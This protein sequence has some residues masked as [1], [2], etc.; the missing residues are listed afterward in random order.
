MNEQ[1][2]PKPEEP[3]VTEP[4]V[5]TTEGEIT[6]TATSDAF[7]LEKGK[8]RAAEAVD[9]VKQAGKEITTRPLL[10][11]VGSYVNRFVEGLIGLAEGME[12]KGKKK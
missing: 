6:D 12:G 11:A 10:D 2:P 5:I 7:T 8:E 4:D 1:F 3:V 9:R